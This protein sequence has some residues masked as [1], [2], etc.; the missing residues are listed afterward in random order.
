MKIEDS[1]GILAFFFM[2][3]YTYIQKYVLKWQKFSKIRSNR[4]MLLLFFKE[5]PILNI[6]AENAIFNNS[7]I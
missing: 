5:N 4:T 3:F 7:W 2:I 6:L 1:M